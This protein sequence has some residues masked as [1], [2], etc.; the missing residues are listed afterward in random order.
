MD[1]EGP[2]RYREECQRNPDF[3][4]YHRGHED[5]FRPAPAPTPNDPLGQI[6]DCR[7]FL[8]ND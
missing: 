5:N 3:P 1:T 8:G 6:M 2:Q 4:E 7:G